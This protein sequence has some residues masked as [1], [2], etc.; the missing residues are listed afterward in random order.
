[1]GGGK[2]PS[3]SST[4]WALDKA[5]PCPEGRKAHPSGL[6]KAVANTRPP[7]TLVCFKA[8]QR[9]LPEPKAPTPSKG[10]PPIRQGGPPNGGEGLNF[11]AWRV[12]AK[13]SAVVGGFPCPVNV[14]KPLRVGFDHGAAPPVVWIPRQG[15]SARH[16][17]RVWISMSP[18]LPPARHPRLGAT[19]VSHLATLATGGPYGA[20]RVFAFPS[21]CR[22]AMPPPF[23]RPIE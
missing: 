23:P 21:G 6:R 10:T 1:M 8:C 14:R 20:P 11:Q 18:L 16:P 4:A 9:P 19:S 2:P 15:P 3:P 22:H 12:W 17:R 5:H 13:S 7:G